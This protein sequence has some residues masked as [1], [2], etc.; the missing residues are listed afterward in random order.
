MF[1]THKTHVSFI[2]SNYLRES[3]TNKKGNYNYKKNIIYYPKN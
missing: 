2:N 1:L 3:N